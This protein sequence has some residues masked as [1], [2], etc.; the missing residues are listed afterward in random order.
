MTGPKTIG[1]W[2]LAQRTARKWSAQ[3]LADEVQATRQAVSLWELGH[4]QP[5]YEHVLALI[6][7]FGQVP[8]ELAAVL[9]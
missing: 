2:V 1:A 5:R 3:A 6:R 8:P 4:T 9:P 7:V